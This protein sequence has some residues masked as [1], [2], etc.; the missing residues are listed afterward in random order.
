MSRVTQSRDDLEKGEISINRT[1][2]TVTPIDIVKSKDENPTESE[3]SIQFEPIAVIHHTGSTSRGSTFGHYR[4]D[5]LDHDS[6]EWIRTSDDEPVKTIDSSNI[7]KQGYIFLYKNTH[8]TKQHDF[9]KDELKLKYA[10]QSSSTIKTSKGKGKG[11]TSQKNLR[12]VDLPVTRDGKSTL[13]L[14]SSKKN[15]DNAIEISTNKESELNV[16]SKAKYSN[17]K[18]YSILS[19]ISAKADNAKKL[20]V[21]K[22]ELTAKERLNLPKKVPTL[23]DPTEPLVVQMKKIHAALTPEFTEQPQRILFGQ[24]T[25]IVPS[26]T[27]VPELENLLR[28]F[29]RF[30]QVPEISKLDE[31]LKQFAEKFINNLCESEITTLD[32]IVNMV[33]EINNNAPHANID[34]W[35]QKVKMFNKNFQSFMQA[36]PYDDNLYDY[37]VIIQVI[38]LESIPAILESEKFFLDASTTNYSS[39]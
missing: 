31:D 24:L 26:I 14:D 8:K 9:E 18:V 2:I 36:E 19:N 32:S 35:L 5:I 33:V 38:I 13:P 12:N 29:L 27:R 37:D 4:A 23:I 1:N 6:K 28:N 7:S 22:N 20:S 30:Y 25:E 39:K 34:E 3:T 11:K 16:K 10:N 15:T 17:P 21:K